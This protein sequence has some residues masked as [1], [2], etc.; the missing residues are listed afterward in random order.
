MYN[1]NSTNSKRAIEKWNVVYLGLD[2]T[3]VSEVGLVSCKSNNYVWTSLSLQFLH[4]RLG[5]DECVLNK[6][7]CHGH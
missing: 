7:T 2:K 4:P 3:L 6:Q 5:P 1:A